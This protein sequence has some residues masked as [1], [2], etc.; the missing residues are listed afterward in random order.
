M[1][2]P[3]LKQIQKEYHGSLKSY[4]I[5]FTASL[6]LTLAAFGLVITKT[7]TGRQLIYTVVGLG[8]VQAIFQLRYFLKLGHEDPPRWETLTFCFM[9]VVLLVIA[10]GSIWVMNDLND[11]L[12]M[13][14]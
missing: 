10:I 4:V 7:L 1:H 13:E 3:N 12:M 5:G 11:R 14:M 8:L 9:V 6:L 2:E